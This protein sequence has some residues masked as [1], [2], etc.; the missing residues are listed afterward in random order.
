[1]KACPISSIFFSR[2][3]SSATPRASA[4]A[5]SFSNL[6][7]SATRVAASSTFFSPSGVHA[8]VVDVDVEVV[9]IGDG[10]DDGDAADDGD[11]SGDADG[12]AVAPVAALRAAS[13]L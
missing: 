2:A 12:D 4:S 8:G 1:M 13:F 7:T 5:R 3:R 9:V 10:D 6:P 11:V